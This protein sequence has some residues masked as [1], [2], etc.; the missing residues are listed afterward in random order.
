MPRF[1]AR[2]LGVVTIL[3]SAHLQDNEAARLLLEWLEECGALIDGT[4]DLEVLNRLAAAGR[5]DKK[6]Q[7]PLTD[8]QVMALR[9]AFERMELVTR[10]QLG[11]D[12]GRAI[13]LECYTSERKGI[14][15]FNCR[16]RDAYLP[17]K[18]DRETDS[19][20][21][22]AEQTPGLK[23]LSDRYAEL[24]RSPTGRRGVGSQQF[25]RLLGANAAPILRK[26][27]NQVQRYVG[28][29][30]KGLYLQIEGSPQERIVEMHKHGA[31]HTLQEYDSPD[32]LA[33]VEDI[34]REL[35]KRTRRKRAAALV[36]TL[37]RA[38]ERTLSDFAEVDSVYAQRHWQPR[39]LMRAYWLW[40]VGDVAWLDDE[41]GTARRPLE[42]RV[43]TPGNAAIYG[44]NS[45]DFLHRDLQQFNRRVVMRA[46]GVSSD[47]SRSELVDRLRRLRDDPNVVDSENS[48]GSVEQEV[49]VV[50]KALA[51]DVNMPSRSELSRA[52]LRREFESGRGLVLTDMGWLPPRGVLAGPP[53][54]GNLRA[55]APSVAD[56]DGLWQALNLR[57]P[58]PEDCLKVVQRIARKGEEP[59]S[60]DK[61]ILLE[62]MRALAAHYSEGDTPKLY[63]RRLERLALWS[64]KGWERKRPIFATSDP[65]LA[66][67]LRDQIPLWEPGGDLEQFR[68]L[69]GPL[70]VKEIQTKDAEVIEPALAVED[71]DATDL[72]RLAIGFLREDLAR[73]EPQLA[74]NLKVPW[75][76]LEGFSV[77]THP[78]LSLRV[79]ALSEEIGQEYLSEVDAKM[80][81]AQGKVFVRDPLTLP[82]VDIGGRALAEVFGGNP[83]RLSLA[84]RAACDKTD[85]GIEARKIDLAHQRAERTMAQIE[86]EINRRTARLQER[87]AGE[88]Q[89]SGG[90]TS[91][92]S[93]SGV[94][95]P[96]NKGKK[97]AAELGAP[98]TLV[99]PNSLRIVDQRGRID[100]PTQKTRPRRDR[101]KRLVEPNE[102]ST[103]LHN[104]TPLPGY[105][106]V[107]KEDVGM[108]LATRILS[109]D[110]NEIVDIRAQRRVGADA[111]DSLKNF[112]ELKVS[113][114]VEPDQVTLTPPEVERALNTPDFFL[115]VVSGVEGTDA[116]P[117][118]RVFVDPLNQLRQTYSGKI[119]LSGIRSAKSLVY[120]FEPNGDSG[121]TPNGEQR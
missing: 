14:R 40:Q 56:T 93:A 21:T 46:I 87:T 83:R 86:E 43:R 62:T 103:T 120:E 61:T 70:R 58:S 49:A 121:S 90:T 27:P 116:R 41:S 18:I 91:K 68:S 48:S 71:S 104:R 108:E 63:K 106:P 15:T 44:E 57:K 59:D 75:D 88:K 6:L 11:P 79:P 55:F 28:D 118:V 20:A 5:S 29:H 65:M 42:L 113:A 54:F 35:K 115:V 95:G 47:P 50:Y 84:W 3:H 110:D 32:L 101:G 98:R 24:L 36:E 10:R 31:S 1:L 60:S 80:D 105:S 77:F 53:I 74:A 82:R 97:K 119:K 17:K 51:H 76:A 102:V 12:V 37:G 67:G 107:D 23:W 38:W 114:G 94:S 2:Q 45:P 19:F 100:E 112:Y 89:S 7:E 81:I 78:T 69:I 34:S 92:R 64:S 99:D 72:F 8:E 66:N 117:K 22:A 96:G 52:Q 25:L 4:D 13:S 73:N 109:S 111:I 26:H 85:E 16:P 33:V 9:D 30:R 39:G